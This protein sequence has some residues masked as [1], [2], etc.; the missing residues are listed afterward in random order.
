[1]AARVLFVVWCLVQA[2]CLTGMIVVLTK[3]GRPAS[4]AHPSTGR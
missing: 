3:L 2:W 1:M 4:E